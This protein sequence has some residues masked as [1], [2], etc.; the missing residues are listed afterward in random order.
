MNFE[1]FKQRQ[2]NGRL[3]ENFKMGVV[4]VLLLS[5]G[6]FTAIGKENTK[7]IILYWAGFM[8]TLVV[9]AGILDYVAW[10]KNKQIGKK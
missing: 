5:L 8:T 2:E 9:V 7:A 4:I 1:E 10:R 3:A 6:L